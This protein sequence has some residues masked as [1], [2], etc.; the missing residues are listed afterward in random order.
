MDSLDKTFVFYSHYDCDEEMTD[1][2]TPL[3]TVLCLPEELSSCLIY[4]RMTE[5]GEAEMCS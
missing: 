2:V 5:K 4:G 3:V 1:P